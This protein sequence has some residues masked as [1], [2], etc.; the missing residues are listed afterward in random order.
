MTRGFGFGSVVRVRSAQ[1]HP[2]GPRI[3]IIAEIR[4][5][6]CRVLYLRTRRSVWVSLRELS[7]ASGEGELES[8]ISGLLSLLDAS[9]MEFTTPRPGCARLKASHGSITPEALEAVKRR[10]GDRLKTC[11]VRPQGMHKIQTVL[12]FTLEPGP[13]EAPR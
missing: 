1:A 13:S 4:K 11:V 8:E 12:E 5:S 10:L 7:A 3:G 6:D 9:E 2:E